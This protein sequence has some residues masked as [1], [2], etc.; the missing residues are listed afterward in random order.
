MPPFFMPTFHGAP[1]MRSDLQSF[2]YPSPGFG[3][4]VR[5]VN[6]ASIL[7]MLEIYRTFEWVR[8]SE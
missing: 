7:G 6:I 2:I 4:T 5:T 8:P 3:R 1:L